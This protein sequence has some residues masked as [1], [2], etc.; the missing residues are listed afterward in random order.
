MDI[1]K[2]FK[3]KKFRKIIKKHLFELIF[4]IS[5]FCFTFISTLLYNQTTKKLESQLI[6][7]QKESIKKPSEKTL[8]SSKIYVDLSGAVE[9]PDVY[10]VSEGARLIDVLKLANGLSANADRSFFY[11]NFNLAQQVFDGQKIYIPSKYEIRKG[12]IS[13]PKRIFDF[14]GYGGGEVSGISQKT[15]YS[16]K[17]SRSKK[18][19]VNTA[20]KSELEDLPGIGK[21]TAQKII[22]N[23]PYSSLNELV[24]KKILR[25]SLFE[26]LKENLTL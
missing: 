16:S 25:K 3:L 14:T 17:T 15:G 9:K 11:R 1:S 23:R 4:L 13:E 10:E 19:N 21:V 8:P 12:L 22:D 6:K 18:V 2:F 7:I 26:E 20:S 5:A 24:D